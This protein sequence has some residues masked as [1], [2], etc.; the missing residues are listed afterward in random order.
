MVEEIVALLNAGSTLVLAVVTIIYATITYFLLREQKRLR[1]IQTE[2]MLYPAV[3]TAL[4]DRD[5]GVKKF[6]V[7]VLH[8]RH[9]RDLSITLSS[10]SIKA[11]LMAN[12]PECIG[13][14]SAE[15]P[16][17]HVY[18]F[19]VTQFV[20]TAVKP[21]KPVDLSVRTDYKSLSGE[22]YRTMTTVQ[23]LRIGQ[24]GGFTYDGFVF[25]TQEEPWRHLTR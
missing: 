22:K 16:F 18:A 25:E 4:P 2:I 7:S 19:D 8:E 9:I 24:D 3:G 17:R 6:V 5:A 12:G 23:S 14:N 10:G 20:N 11:T 21:G 15:P 1:Q 13:Y